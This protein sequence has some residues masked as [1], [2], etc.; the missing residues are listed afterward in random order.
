MPEIFVSGPHSSLLSL[1]VLR[2]YLPYYD[3]D[4]INYGERETETELRGWLSAKCLLPFV[5]GDSVP[6][7]GVIIV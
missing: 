7:F 1:A 3:I 2:F 6:V 5:L 4:V